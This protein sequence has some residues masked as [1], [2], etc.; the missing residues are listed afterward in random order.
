[1]KWR[2]MSSVIYAWTEVSYH[3]QEL[4]WDHQVKAASAYVL[5][6]LKTLPVQKQP[7]IFKYFMPDPTLRS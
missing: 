3:L 6:I 4:G 1:M 5:K 7:M 2:C